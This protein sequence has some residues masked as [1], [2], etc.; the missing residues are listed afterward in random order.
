[1]TEDENEVIGCAAEFI[2][3][4]VILFALS[5]LLILHTY[6]IDYTEIAESL[7]IVNF[8]ALIDI[9]CMLYKDSY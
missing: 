4:K 9:V 1:M 7:W 8:H 2:K 3:G 6:T 5:Y